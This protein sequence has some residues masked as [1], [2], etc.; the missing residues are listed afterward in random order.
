MSVLRAAGPAT[1]SAISSRELEARADDILRCAEREAAELLAGI[2]KAKSGGDSVEEPTA[3]RPSPPTP[4][5]QWL[6]LCRGGRF[7]G[8]RQATGS[9]RRLSST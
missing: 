5:Q 4:C 7:A 3:V 1:L 6:A 2:E 9:T 8:D